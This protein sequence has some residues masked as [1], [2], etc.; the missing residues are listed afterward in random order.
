[1]HRVD[2]SVQLMTFSLHMDVALIHVH[3][4]WMMT[5]IIMLNVLLIDDPTMDHIVVPC[6]SWFESMMKK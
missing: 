3:L 2:E 5:P 1:M 4:V 6:S